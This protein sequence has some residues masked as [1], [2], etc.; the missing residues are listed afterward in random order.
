[1]SSLTEE[2]VLSGPSERISEE[3]VSRAVAKMKCNKAAGP[4]GV[5]ADMLKSAGEICLP[6]VMEVCNAI[7]REG[8]RCLQRQG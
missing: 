7:V 2:G 6:W 8:V 1:M 4:S 5:V 3:E